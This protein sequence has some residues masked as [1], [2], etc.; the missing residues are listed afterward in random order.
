[1]AYI[2][3]LVMRFYLYVLCLAE[4]YGHRVIIS[5]ATCIASE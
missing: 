5:Y 4:S 1:M 3:I 2:H